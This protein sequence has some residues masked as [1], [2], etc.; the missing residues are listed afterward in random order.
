[1]LVLSTHER[2]HFVVIVTTFRID[3]FFFILRSVRSFANEKRFDD[4]NESDSDDDNDYNNNNNDNNNSS[5]K[6]K[7]KQTSSK[8]KQSSKR[9]KAKRYG[10]IY[11][12]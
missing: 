5:K 7:R 1:M 4:E 3:I 2:D 6:G 11:R 8:T 12:K 10:I 9:Q